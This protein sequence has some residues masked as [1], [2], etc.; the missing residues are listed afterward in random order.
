MRRLGPHLRE[1]TGPQEPVS[2]EAVLT[3]IEGQ[4]L[5]S[6]SSPGAPVSGRRMLFCLPFYFLLLIRIIMFP[7]Y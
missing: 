2:P 4:G 5:G 7:V 6:E 1:T 3:A